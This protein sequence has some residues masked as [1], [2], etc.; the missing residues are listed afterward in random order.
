MSGNIL[1]V[2]EQKEGRAKNATWELV[3]LGQHLAQDLGKGLG[4]VMLGRGLE[5]GLRD[6]S[7][8][9]VDTIYSADHPRLENYTPE[10]YVKVLKSLIE[11]QKPYLVL[12]AHSTTGVDFAPR[13]SAACH[14]LLISACVGYAK[15]GDR[16]VFI[17]QVFN[18]KLNMKMAFRGEPPY[19][20]SVQAGAFSADDVQAG[21][22]AAPV[23]PVAVNLTEADVPRKVIERIAAEKGEADLSQA[24]IIISGGR[25]LGKKENFS[26]I[27]DLAKAIGG[28][29]GASRPVVDAEWLPRE[30]QIGS[31]GQTVNPKLYIACGIS[32][33]IQHL[34]GM[35]T[36]RCIVAINKDANAPIFKVAHYG[37][38]D[39]LFKVIPAL[40]KAINEM[41]QKQV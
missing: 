23:V 26:Y 38:V 28:A 15:E 37:V 13:L 18:A 39:D 40:I 8:K 34:V 12:I 10:A 27:F 9:K 19:F 25:G 22:G 17:R 1:I 36:S 2:A 5:S 30:Y 41:K 6:L 11:E 24:P 16:P 21:S 14:A 33:A 32:G 20:V 7:L 35:Q 3:A 31:S 29:V 4:V